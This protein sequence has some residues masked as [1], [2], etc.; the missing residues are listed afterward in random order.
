MFQTGSAT[1]YWD[2]LKQLQEVATSRHMATAAISAGG[3]GYVVGDILS[4][5]GGTKTHTAT[6]E[7]LTVAAGVITSIRVNEGGAY[8]VDP[9]TTGNVVTGGTGT[10][11]TINLTMANTGWTVLRKSKRAASATIAGGGSGYA[12]NDEIEVQGG[13]GIDVSGNVEKAVFVVDAVSGGAVTAVSVKSGSEG[14]YEETPSNPVSV[15]DTVGGGNNDCTLTVTYAEIQD[16][17]SILV[18]RGA[19]VGAPDGPVIGFRTYDGVQGVFDVRNWALF[20]FVTWNGSVLMHD[21]AGI[22]P[23]LKIVADTSDVNPDINKGCPNLPLKDNDGGGSYP[24]NFW[25]AMNDR[26]I[27]VVVQCETA[28]I[29]AFVTLH[30]GFLNQFGTTEEIPYPLFIGGSATQRN[31][32]V[33]D[34]STVPVLTSIVQ[35]GN[36][37]GWTQGPSYM[38]EPSAVWRRVS[39]FSLNSS[40]NDG[41]DQNEYV[42]YPYMYGNNPELPISTSTPDDILSSPDAIDLL[43]MTEGSI[44]V[45]PTWR[46]FPT[47]DSTEPLRL[48][49]PSTVLVSEGGQLTD[50]RYPFGELDGVFWFSYADGGAGAGPGDFFDVGTT[51]YRVFRSGH[52]TELDVDFF[53]IREA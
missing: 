24:L 27:I 8:T 33:L 45:T 3:T 15:I 31:C 42:C 53:A 32:S 49:I 17:H 28:L 40:N 2:L 20:G 41:Q 30:I 18:M 26:R 52:R 44:A 13:L 4:I 9:T 35:Q 5:A 16:D 46:L 48:L 21:N 12:V 43:D 37:D 51:R 7:V 29:N 23:G 1:D 25:F 19:A 14:I 39:N 47:P 22:S 50:I 11:A 34:N 6:I 10:G 38:L 36:D